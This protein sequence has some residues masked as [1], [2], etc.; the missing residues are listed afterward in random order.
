[1]GMYG[2][3]TQGPSSYL[4]LGTPLSLA[5]C[6]GADV[7]VVEMVTHCT[8]AEIIEF[9]RQRPEEVGL[10]LRCAVNRCSAEVCWLL[11]RRF[12]TNFAVDSVYD[13]VS[14]LMYFSDIHLLTIRIGLGGSIWWL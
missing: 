10:I 12:R 3:S 2:F 1:M 9:T 14:V 4:Q 5:A 8:D 7:I 11:F 6:A 13:K